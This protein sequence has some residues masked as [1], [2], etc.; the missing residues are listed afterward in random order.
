MTA[1][2]TSIGFSGVLNIGRFGTGDAAGTLSSPTIAFNTGS[3]RINFNQAD[4]TTIS[5]AISGTGSLYQLGSGTTI[6]TGHNTYTGT[7]VVQNGTL[8]VEGQGGLGD[9]AVSAG[10]VIGGA[11]SLGGSLFLDSGARL[12]FRQGQPLTVNGASVTFG[13]F[14]IADLVGLDGTVPLGAYTIINGAAAIDFSNLH[15]V[16]ESNA[17]DIGGGKRAFFSSGSL[18]VNVV[19]E[20]GTCIMALAGLACGGFSLRR[21]SAP[22]DAAAAISRR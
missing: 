1:T 2:R 22:C 10:G 18:I 17:Y 12:L 20:P 11:G 9:V 15:H 6:L 7:T 8:L 19:P 4:T 3:G 5:S 13:G 16:G 14:D 21:R